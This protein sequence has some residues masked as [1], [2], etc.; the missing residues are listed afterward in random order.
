MV[1]ITDSYITKLLIKKYFIHYISGS[2]F[3][4]NLNAKK[5]LLVTKFLKMWACTLKIKE[6][7]PMKE[8]K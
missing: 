5:L 2:V 1:H 8:K 7:N 6:K 3:I 4:K